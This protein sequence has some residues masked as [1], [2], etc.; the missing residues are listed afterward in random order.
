MT[1]KPGR[2]TRVKE[3]FICFNCGTEVRGSGYTDHC[4]NCLWSLHVDNNPGDRAS[5]CKGRMRPASAIYDKGGYTIEYTCEK[6]GTRKRFKASE[7]DNK[8][9][10]MSLVKMVM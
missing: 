6:C 5:G 10:L 8:E 3:D 2:F 1:G 4:P 7:S 9:L